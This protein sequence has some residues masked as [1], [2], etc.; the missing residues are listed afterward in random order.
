MYEFR[1]IRI[2]LDNYWMLISAKLYCFLRTLSV[3]TIGDN[4]HTGKAE[5]F[6]TCIIIF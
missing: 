4:M 2:S 1:I 5:Y 3:D 6:D